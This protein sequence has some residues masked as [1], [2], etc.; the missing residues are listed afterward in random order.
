[1]LLDCS[2]TL[3]CLIYHPKFVHDP[4]YLLGTEKLTVPLSLP[5]P[6]G[7][8]ADLLSFSSL[9]LFLLIAIMPLCNCL[10]HS[11]KVAN[12]FCMKYGD[13][14]EKRGGHEDRQK[15][16][17]SFTV[18]FFQSHTELP[19]LSAVTGLPMFILSTR[20]YLQSRQDSPKCNHILIN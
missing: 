4:H 12:P 9:L 2:Y 1:M 5:F 6:A 19:L 8:P 11:P 3:S 14:G 17:E 18:S 10:C 13:S 20:K 7:V 15:H 16:R